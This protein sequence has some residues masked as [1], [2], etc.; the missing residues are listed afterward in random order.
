MLST[1]NV[2]SRDQ[3]KLFDHRANEEAYFACFATPFTFALPKDS[4]APD[5]AQYQIAPKSKAASLVAQVLRWTRRTGPQL[6]LAK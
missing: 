2:L 6:A 1:L 4:T 3:G 5:L